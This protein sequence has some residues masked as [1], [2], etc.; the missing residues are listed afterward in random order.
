[1]VLNL[2]NPTAPQLVS[3][4]EMDS[5]SGQMYFDVNN[6]Y[7]YTPNRYTSDLTRTYDRLLRVNV[8][9]ASANFMQIEEF[10]A[11][12]DPFGVAFDPVNNYL[13]VT[14]STNSLNYYDITGTPSEQDLNM[15]V[16]MSNNEY[17]V[18]ANSTEVV[19]LNRQAFVTRTYG[20]LFVIDLDEIDN[21]NANAVDYLVYNI[22]SPRG[23]ATDGTYIYLAN[24][25]VVNDVITPQLLVIDPVA[26]PPRIGN[27]DMLIID[28]GNPGIIFATLTPGMDPQEVTAGRDFVFVT[29]I[30]ENMVSMFS[31]ANKT[32]V[33]N[34][35]VGQEP[36]G[37][38]I[39]SPGG[40]DTHLYVCNI[41]SNNISIIDIAQQ[42]AV[43]TYP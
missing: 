17:L 28:K 35:T 15:G 26:L 12:T 14:N 32:A 10:T 22:T 25:E 31:I 11:G 40:I 8:N 43:A 18:N 24:Q 34:I 5:F 33:T 23:I 3:S 30:S 41:E 29:S 7:I 38:A 37:M 42:A 4:V 6:S 16:L 1:M 20:G 21:P 36:F 2:V 13:L 9:E 39:Y 27:S 19:V